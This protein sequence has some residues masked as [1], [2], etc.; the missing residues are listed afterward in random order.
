MSILSKVLK[1][2]YIFF[3]SEKWSDLKHITACEIFA[4]GDYEI[5]SCSLL[6]I[7]EMITN[8]VST[9]EGDNFTEKPQLNLQYALTSLNTMQ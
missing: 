9:S 2:I 5:A 7:D 3:P 4:Q 6:T 8:D 1:L